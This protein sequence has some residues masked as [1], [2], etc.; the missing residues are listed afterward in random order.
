MITVQ[1][2]KLSNAIMRVFP[3]TFSQIIVL[4]FSVTKHSQV[5]YTSRCLKPYDMF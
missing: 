2:Q 1:T 4:Y 5:D 3:L